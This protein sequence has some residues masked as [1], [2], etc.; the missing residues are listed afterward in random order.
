MA[1]L[2]V[3]HDLWE[4]PERKTPRELARMYNL[5]TVLTLALATAVSYVVLFI[6]TLLAAALLTDTSVLRQTLQRPVHATDY[7]TLAWIISSLATVGGAIGSGLE[8]EQTVRA[9]AYGHH[10]EP[11]SPSPTTGAGTRPR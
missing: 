1:W 8:D 5:G 9:A 7:L 11:A 3:A 4:K 6:G 2:I 10:P